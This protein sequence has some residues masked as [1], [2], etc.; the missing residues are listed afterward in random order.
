MIIMVIIIIKK[1]IIIMDY[2]YSAHVC[3]S[4][5]LLAQ[6]HY[7]SGSSPAAIAALDQYGIISYRVPNIYYTW[8][9][10]D[11]C[12]QNALSKGIS[13]KRESN[14]RGS[15]VIMSRE[16]EPIQYSAPT[17]KL[18]LDSLPD[19][20]RIYIY[21]HYYFL[22]FLLSAQMVLIEIDKE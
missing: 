21:I 12:G 17:L 19:Y 13:T 7:Y 20:R 16:H 2:Y 11:N 1:T 6:N 10:R 15:A 22:T 9:E 8:V 3:H 5:T 14:P 18:Y 4:V